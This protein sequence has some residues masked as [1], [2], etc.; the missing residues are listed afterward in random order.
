METR[1]HFVLIGSSVVAVVVMAMMFI[2][3]LGNTERAFDE[4]YVVFNE[5]VSGLQVGAAVQFNGIRVG[6][7]EE[8][9]LDNRDPNIAVAL[10][11]VE[12]NTP[13]R[14]TTRAELELVGVT[15]LSIIQFVGGDPNAPLLKSISDRRIPTIQGSA[16][17]LA[18]VIESSGPLAE[19]ITSLVSAENIDR[20]GRILEDIESLT[21]A[22]ADKDEDI[23][24]IIEN[25]ATISIILRRN[26]EALDTTVA[27][28]NS[29]I[30]ET[31][32]ML[33][34]DVKQTLEAAATSAES[35]SEVIAEIEDILSE[36]RPAIDAFAQE[37]L[38]ATVGVIAQANR[39]LATT[40]AIL[41]EFDRD[42]ARFL[43]GE[44]RPEARP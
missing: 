31:E 6:E 12:E 30:D 14:E 40:E 15:G 17:G 11:R 25:V 3:W 19:N 39:V 16:G 24:E 2:L 26:A 44:N 21:D 43:L 8:L 27:R 37:G 22:I 33:R 38:G 1:A 10:I 20:I 9:G 23:G 28:I 18:A 35:L 36:N 34:T 41:Q 42:P 4:Y 32:G 7:V 13:I 29:I 5:R